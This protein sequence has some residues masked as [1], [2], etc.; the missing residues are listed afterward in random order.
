MEEVWRPVVGYEGQYEVSN[1]GR[2]RSLDRIVK[3]RV[4]SGQK[5]KGRMLTKRCH[6]GYFRVALSENNSTSNF[7]VHR[8]VAAAFIPNPENLPCVN[9]KNENKLDNR[10]ENLEWCTYEYNNNYGMR[11]EK[12]WKKI[13][14][15]NINGDFVKEWTSL[16]QIKN[17]LNYDI[18]TICHI[19]RGDKGKTAYGYLWK[20]A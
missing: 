19:C 11:T 14:Q 6:K 8:L 12:T 15:L 9:H 13:L 1:L 7:F 20:Y 17:E 18:G 4:R 2:V 3:S 10:V 5:I 16:T